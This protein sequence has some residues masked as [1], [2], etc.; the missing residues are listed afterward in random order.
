[1]R[2][3]GLEDTP[4]FQ[5]DVD[6]QRA[7]ALG[8]SLADVNSTLASTWG[9]AYVNDF[10]DKGRT[11]RVYMQADAPFRMQP[12]DVNRWYVRNRHGDMVPFASLATGRWTFGSPK[13]E[14][15]NGIPAVAIQG[16][17]SPGRSSGD[18]MTAMEGIAKQLPAGIGFE[19]SGLSYEERLSGASRS[20]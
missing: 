4:Q 15:F 19:W 7:T 8:V 11:K 18:A 13:L 3:S 12:Q 16:E 17:P 10:M 20:R 9:V 2:P 1:M 6:Q 14:R 5:L